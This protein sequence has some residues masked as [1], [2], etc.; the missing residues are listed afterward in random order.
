MGHPGCGLSAPTM[1]M[2]ASWG[3][4]PW[5]TALQT[6][7]ALSVPSSPEA[8]PAAAT[9]GWTEGSL[10]TNQSESQRLS[11]DMLLCACRATCRQ[12]VCKRYC[13]SSVCVCG[14]EVSAGFDPVGWTPQ[15]K[16]VG[17]PLRAPAASHSCPLAPMSTFQS[18]CLSQDSV[19]IL[20]GLTQWKCPTWNWAELQRLH[21]G[22]CSRPLQRRWSWP[23]K[24][25]VWGR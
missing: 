4:E 3:T 20:R 21:C 16:A 23:V 25:P 24:N 5:L 12:K 15:T 11:C 8:A 9:S 14:G 1:S 13:S 7:A 19:H 18:V 6:P 17:A 22:V 2:A 10:R